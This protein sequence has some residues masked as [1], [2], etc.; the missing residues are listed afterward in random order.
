MA[1][2]ESLSVAAREPPCG[3]AAEEAAPELAPHGGGPAGPSSEC[4]STCDRASDEE[5]ACSAPAETRARAAP[6]ALVGPGPAANAAERQAAAGRV[7]VALPPTPEEE[8]AEICISTDHAAL[9]AE[10]RDMEAACLG[11]SARMGDASGLVERLGRIGLR[12]AE[13]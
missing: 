1:M 13:R 7:S 3:G 6:A 2:V 9:L 4:G 8:P 5:N 12:R 11:M 10:L